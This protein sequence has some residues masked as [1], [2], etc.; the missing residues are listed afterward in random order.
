MVNNKKVVLSRLRG[1]NGGNIYQECELHNFRDTAMKICADQALADLKSL[2]YQMRSRLEWS[3][4]NL[5]T[6]VTLSR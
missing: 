2:D 6:T 3:D 5:I 4:I 1:E